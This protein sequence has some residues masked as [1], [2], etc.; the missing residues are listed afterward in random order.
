MIVFDLQCECGLQF[1]GW[2]D[3]RADFERQSRCSKIICPQC[4]NAKITKL[5]SSFSLPRHRDSQ[6]IPSRQQI[7]GEEQQISAFFKKVGEYVERHFEDVGPKL[8]E[9]SLK[10]HYG[11]TDQRNIRGVATE[12]EEKMLESEG[13]EL[14]KIPVLRDPT[15]DPKVN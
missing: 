8:A 1:E 2:F 12:S 9:E 3:S 7:S 5:Y 10:M 13:I 6:D 14:L 11:V 4:G 15:K